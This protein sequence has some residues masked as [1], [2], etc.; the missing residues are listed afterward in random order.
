MI[1]RAFLFIVERKKC[2][3]KKL[4]MWISTLV[5]LCAVVS[6]LPLNTLALEWDGSSSG[7]GG[8][9][10]PANANGYAIRTT[11]DNCLGYRFSLVDK[12]GNTKGGKVIDVF[13]NTTYGNYEYT[14]GY[15]FTVKYNK[16][17]LINNQ[18]NSFGTS[19]NTT[20]CYKEANMGFASTLPTPDR[21]SSWQSN[22]SN[23]NRILS[24]LGIGSV[25]SLKNGD[26]VLVEPLYDVRLQGI[27]SR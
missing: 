18:N 11:D 8:G 5:I 25:G 10:S 2:M 27:S 23:L 16:K 22:H 19:K 24:V 12:S 9:G 14:N 15:K 21:M 7:G 17:Q 13:R 20:N 1:I 26:K 4:F 3:K 6:S